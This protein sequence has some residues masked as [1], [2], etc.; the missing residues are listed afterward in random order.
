MR[1]LYLNYNDYVD[2]ANQE[3]F[4]LSRTNG[5]LIYRNLGSE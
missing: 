4:T 3:T 2:D 5:Y 1:E